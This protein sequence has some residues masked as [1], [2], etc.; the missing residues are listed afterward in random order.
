MASL[1]VHRG[2]QPRQAYPKSLVNALGIALG[3]QYSVSPW[4][5]SSDCGRWGAFWR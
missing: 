5:G 2:R 3:G 4:L 1:F